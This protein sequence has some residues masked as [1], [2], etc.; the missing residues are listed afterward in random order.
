MKDPVEHRQEGNTEVLMLNRP[1]AYNAMDF[2]LVQGLMERLL[3][4][5][6]DDRVRAVVVSGKGKAFCAGG[7]LKWMLGYPHGI[8]PA[9][10]VLASRLHQ[11]LTEIRKMKKP[12]IAAINGTAA[13]AGL[14]LALACD[15]RVMARSTFLQQAYTSAG[16]CIDG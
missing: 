11:A 16:L 7:D 5:T 10:H 3:H 6:T 15:L 4:I 12:V 13:G 9:L 8:S 2:D 14:S 1:E